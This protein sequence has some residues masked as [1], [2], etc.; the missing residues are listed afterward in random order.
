MPFGIVAAGLI[1]TDGQTADAVSGNAVR[2][3]ISKTISHFGSG[4]GTGV[5]AGGFYLFGRIEKDDRARETGLLASE[6]LIDAQIIVTVLKTATQRARPLAGERRGRFFTKGNS[7]PSGHS[8]SAWALAT[9]VAHEYKDKP[10]IKYGAYGLAA[11]VSVARYTGRKHFLSDAAVG[12]V[13]GYGIGRYVYRAH[14]DSSL[15]VDP[16]QTTKKDSQSRLLPFIVPQFN[17]R[18]RSYGAALN[19]NF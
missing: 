13:I 2:R 5:V 6:A 7:F 16:K 3:R 18:A 8:A 12:S 19:W 17:R 4:Y 11:A 14:H 9:V 10:L 1:A 15:D